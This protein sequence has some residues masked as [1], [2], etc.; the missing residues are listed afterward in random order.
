MV[1]GRSPFATHDE[2][3]TALERID[4]FMLDVIIPLAAKTNAVV[5]CEAVQTVGFFDSFSH[6]LSTLSLSPP[7]LPLSLC[8]SRLPSLS[9]VPSLSRSY[10]FLLARSRYPIPSLQ[11]PPF[12]DIRWYEQA[13]VLSSSLRRC[14]TLMRSRWNGKVPFTVLSVTSETACFYCNSNLDAEWRRVRRGCRCF[15]QLE[16]YRFNC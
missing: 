5:V 9:H 15:N 7:P 11:F 8:L 10:L 12:C 13:C 2:E 14:V 3:R 16:R 6:L 4:A 1:H